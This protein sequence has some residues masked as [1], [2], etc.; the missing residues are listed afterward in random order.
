MKNSFF[1]KKQ[2]YKNREF[3]TILLYIYHKMAKISSPPPPPFPPQKL[4]QKGNKKKK[5]NP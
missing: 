5:K 1:G 4:P 3:V 2:I